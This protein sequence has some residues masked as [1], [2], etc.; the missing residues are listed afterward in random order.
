MNERR[1]PSTFVVFSTLAIIA[2]IAG[3]FVFFKKQQTSAGLP[4]LSSDHKSIIVD[5][6]ILLSIDHD[7]IF[8]WFKV[9]SQL[10]D[11]DSLTSVP[12]RKEFCEDTTSFKDQTRFASVV[13]SPDKTKIGF[14]IESDT[15]SPDKVVGIFFRHTNKVNLLTS[16]YLGNE[17][18]S[19]SPS[20]KYFVYQG[21]CWENLC[22]LFVNDSETLEEIINLNNPEFLDSRSLNAKFVRWPSDSQIEYQLGSELRQESL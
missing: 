8:N 3:Y 5:N 17:F 9:E 4:S 7:V 10:C 15:L 12:N 2:G 14:S 13:V 22:G 6:S 1:F 20:G 18:L 16:Y 19:F 21:N 11:G